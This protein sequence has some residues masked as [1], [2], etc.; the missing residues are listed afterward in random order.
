[1]PEILDAFLR[2]CGPG[3]EVVKG[4]L[5]LGCAAI[6]LEGDGPTGRHGLGGGNI[7]NLD[8]GFASILELGRVVPVFPDGEVMAIAIEQDGGVVFGQ[9][10]DGLRCGVVGRG[11]ENKEARSVGIELERDRGDL[12]VVFV[13]GDGG[14][15]RR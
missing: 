14:P 1:M 13:V 15:L 4:N 8:L 3:N 11:A 6:F 2:A 5:A 12:A 10:G 7:A 9:L